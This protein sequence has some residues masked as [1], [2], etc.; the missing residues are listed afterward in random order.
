MLNAISDFFQRSLSQP[1]QRENQTLTLELATAA[2]LCE[3]VRA[4]YDTTN[5]ELAALRLM[6]TE[7][8]RLS[9][10]DVEELMALAQAEVDEAVDHY[11]FVS[12]I[13]EHYNYDQ[14]C[15][16]VA[17]MWQLAWADGSVDPLEEHRI[18]R[19]ADLLYVSH[20]DFIR[21]KLHVEERNKPDA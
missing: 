13:K 20:S 17:Q 9:A 6:L 8:Y 4:D 7:R 1:E 12:L 19:L 2:L 5:E 11:Q 21:T 14:R 10:S 16:L 3:I 18:R 15:E